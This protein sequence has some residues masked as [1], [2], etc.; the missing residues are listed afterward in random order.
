MPK[1]K[2]TD[3]Q[4]KAAYET[5]SN[6][7]AIAKVF[8]CAVSTIHGRLS[9]LGLKSKKPHQMH[10]LQGHKLYVVWQ[11]MKKRVNDP[12]IK[13]FKD[14]GGRG[15][16]ICSIWEKDFMSFYWFCIN[17]GWTKKLQID[18]IDNDG[19][20]EPGNCRFVTSKENNRNQRL[21][22]N[23]NKSGYRGICLHKSTNKWQANIKHTSKL[24]YLGIYTELKDAVE[25]RNTY[26]LDNN[27]Q[28]EYKIQTYI[29][30]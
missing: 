2:F 10:G 16:T 28:D 29:E 5:E 12:N 17:N 8:N 20:Y 18:R 3:Q 25:A 14:Y 21:L 26:I 6:N 7:T 13:Q 23:N 4:L 1:S 15:I 22:K 27:L 30:D 9:K 24:V 19:N 11:N